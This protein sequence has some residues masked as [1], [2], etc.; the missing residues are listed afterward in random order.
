MTN[1]TKRLLTMFVLV[2][3]MLLPASAHQQANPYV[4]AWTLRSADATGAVYWLEIKEQN[5][6]LTGMFLNGGGH[7]LP[8]DSVKIENG[9][10]R[11]FNGAAPRQTEYRAR[12]EGDKLIVHTII[13]PGRRG[14][15]PAQPTAAPVPRTVNWIG[16]KPPV[17]PASNANGK[18]TYGPPVVLFDGKSL[19]TFVGQNPNAPLNWSVVDGVMTN[20]TKP[21]NNLVSKQKFQNFKVECEFKVAEHTNSGIYLRGRYELQ[22]LNDL[23]DTTTE[24][25]LTQMAIYGRVAPAV[26]ASKGVDEWQ[27]MEAI[28]VGNRVTVTFNGKRVHD[29]V[30]IVGVTGGALDGDELSPGPLMIQGDHEQ[31]WFRKVVVTPIVTAGK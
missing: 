21:A 12:I 15:D 1:D 31:V 6:Q 17:W 16:V 3:G 8:L 20:P 10:L 2:L 25:F 4:G 5:G 23:N 29:N 27:T 28:L 9:E 13:A 30:A 26:K 19:D 11:F 7:A 24:P 14:A 22:V 18:H